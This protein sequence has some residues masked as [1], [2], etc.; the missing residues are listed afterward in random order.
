MEVDCAG[1]AGCCLDWRPLAPSG[2]DHE[3]MGPDTPLDDRY[4][5]VPLTRDDI[6]DLVDAGYG[7]A[8]RPRV[9]TTDAEDR[10]TVTVDG[11]PLVAVQDRPVFMLGLRQPPKPVGPFGTAP[12][13]LRACVFLDPTTL[14]CRIHGA[15]EYPTTCAA[16]PGQHLALDAET[17]CDRVEATYGG[18]RLVERTPPTESPPL[19]LGP[20]ALGWTAFAHPDPD[21][22]VG[23]IDHL[24]EDTLTAADRAAF[25]GP[26][27]GHSPGT[28][29]IN[30][31]VAARVSE[32][33][34]TAASWAGDAARAW[35]DAAEAGNAPVPTLAEQLETGRGAPQTPGWPSVDSGVE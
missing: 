18:E 4:N 23:R 9:W 24:R 30:E 32:A 13:W 26:A 6:Q 2:T 10:A 35:A 27:A 33:V 20:E 15:E 11:V 31:A 29:A 1:C 8:V 3:R 12:R 16:Y 5:L 21:D 14:Q 17:E 28:L 19:P 34:R 7:D 25:A 22:L